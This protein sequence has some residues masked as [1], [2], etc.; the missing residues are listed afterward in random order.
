MR[1]IDA[2]L[3]AAVLAAGCST[4]R[5]VA[6]TFSSP[7]PQ[8]QPSTT[9][10]APTVGTWGDDPHWI[11]PDDFFI[12][13]QG[14]NNL[15]VAKIATHPSKETEMRGEFIFVRSGKKTWS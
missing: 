8:G 4:S 3:T 6:N 13:D 5:V 15:Y 10:E 11:D 12:F 7:A 2:L 1:P 14:Y 9:G